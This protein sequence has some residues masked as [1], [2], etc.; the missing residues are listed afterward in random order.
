[1]NA[2]PGPAPLVSIITV[3]LNAEEHVH[4]AMESVL[5]QSYPQVEYIVVD[6]AST[7]TTLDIVRELEPSFGGRL[8]WT[9]EPDDGLYDA[10]NKGIAM[11][12]GGL[13]GIVNADD[14]YEPSA[15]ETAVATWRANPAAGVIYGPMRAIEPGKPS[16]TLGVPEAISL[17]DLRHDMIIRH[18]A[19]FITAS[20]YQHVGVYDTSYPIAADYDFL[21]RCLESGVEFAHVAEVMSNF[22]LFGTS[23]T[24]IRNADR[25]ATRVRVAHG[26]NPVVAWSRYYKRA[27]A[28]RVYT[29]LERYP[30]FTKAYGKHKGH[31]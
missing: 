29:A 21:L 22:S 4:T 3:C 15:V 17:A 19:T 14:F 28:Y 1:M 20:T 18:P 25:D 24:Q 27:I 5:A 30:W 7:D 16:R 23:Q 26:V 11:A 31:I 2:G 12:A 13:I 8:R 6:G 9:S 10:M